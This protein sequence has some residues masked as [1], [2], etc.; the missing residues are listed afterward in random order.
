MYYF[1]SQVLAKSKKYSW[2]N[3]LR[4][5]KKD[6][7]LK[8]NDKIVM[9]KIRFRNSNKIEKTKKKF[10]KYQEMAKKYLEIMYK[11]DEGEIDKN[12][13]DFLEMNS[14]IMQIELN[15]FGLGTGIYRRPFNLGVFKDYQ[16]IAN[17]PA[18]FKNQT[19]RKQVSS[20]ISGIKS[21]LN[22]YIHIIDNLLNDKQKLKE[23]IQKKNRNSKSIKKFNL[24]KVKI[25]EIIF[26]GIFVLGL[27]FLVEPKTFVIGFVM[28][29]IAVI[30]IFIIS[31]VNE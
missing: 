28:N 1:F 19:T 24:N 22:T 25:I 17:F 14:G 7:N 30:T 12:D 6:L 21:M 29:L 11:I 20:F 4:V 16:Y 13:F 9:N 2:S 18:L 3:N 27:T 10:K 26:L 31:M 23:S 8:T 15:S 5:N